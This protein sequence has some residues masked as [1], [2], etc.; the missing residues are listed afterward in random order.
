MRKTFAAGARDSSGMEPHGV[1][2]RPPRS[3]PVHG[4]PGQC[5]RSSPLG[6]AI[7]R[8]TFTTLVTDWRRRWGQGDFPFLFVQ[9]PNFG[10]KENWPVIREAQRQ[11]R[12]VPKT[13]MA[14]TIDVGDPKDLHPADKAPVGRRL[15]L[16][17]RAGVYGE[18]VVASGPTL[19][20]VEADGAAMVLG[21][22][23]V[24]QGLVALKSVAAPV[25]VEQMGPRVRLCPRLRWAPATPLSSRSG[26]FV[27]PAQ[28]AR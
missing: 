4:E 23:N 8:D 28:P 2:L 27:G 26:K 21:F 3:I 18:P 10:S 7:Y 25:G 12:A 20:S 24:G 11:S 14:V 19:T 15:A 5:I 9:L 6:I 13:G 17:A 16:L 1:P 22:A